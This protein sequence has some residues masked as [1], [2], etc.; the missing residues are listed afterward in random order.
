M[1][2]SDVWLSHSG[3]TE[4]AAREAGKEDCVVEHITAPNTMGAVSEEREMGIS[5]QVAAPAF[6]GTGIPWHWAYFLKDG[7]KNFLNHRAFPIS[8]LR[9]AELTVLL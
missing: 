5:Q 3:D 2:A 7:I 8:Y 4:L 9:N 1:V 6:L